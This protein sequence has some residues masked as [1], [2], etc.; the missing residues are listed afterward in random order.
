MMLSLEV[1][2]FVSWSRSDRNP[3]NTTKQHLPVMRCSHVL[4][5]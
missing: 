2:F 5:N 4:E 3:T 1:C